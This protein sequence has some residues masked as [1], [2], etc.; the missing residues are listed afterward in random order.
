MT[1]RLK[2]YSKWKPCYYCGAPPPSTQEHA[3]PR[4]MFAAF[5]CDIITVPSC[6]KHNT[7]KAGNDRAV[8]TALVRSLHQTL[9][10]RDTTNCLPE[11]VLK[12]ISFLEPDF[13]KANRE[14]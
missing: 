14:L 4:L 9:E 7:E 13:R 11:N 1:L 2:Q 12:A 5:D 8:I 3:P 10:Y 6:E